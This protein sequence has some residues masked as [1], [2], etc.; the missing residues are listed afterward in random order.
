VQDRQ[1]LEQLKASLPRRKR[2]WTARLHPQA[3]AGGGLG[4]LVLRHYSC[5]AEEVMTAVTHAGTSLYGTLRKIYFD[6]APR[7]LQEVD[8]AIN[9]AE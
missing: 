8:A 6:S 9:A 2:E 1:K 3:T 7:V 4:R 5:A